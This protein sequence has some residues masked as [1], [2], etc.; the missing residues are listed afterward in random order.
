MRKLTAPNLLPSSMSGGNT[1]FDNPALAM[2]APGSTSV[3][4]FADIAEDVLPEPRPTERPRT[5]LI[6]RDGSRDS[7]APRTDPGTGPGPDHEPW[8]RV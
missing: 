5:V 4:N 7:A 8:T 1:V 2:T 3:D 6:G